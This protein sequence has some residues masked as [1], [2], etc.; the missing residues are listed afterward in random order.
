M[1]KYLAIAILI[2]GF[3]AGDAYA[4]G[5]F[6]EFEEQAGKGLNRRD[7]T[8]TWSCWGHETFGYINGGKKR[9]WKRAIYFD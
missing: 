3:L 8:V 9:I 4:D 1:T 2:T 7:N 6:K 5:F